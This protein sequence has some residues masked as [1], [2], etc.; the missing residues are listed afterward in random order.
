MQFKIYYESVKIMNRNILIIAIIVIIIAAV[1]VF[2]FTQPHSADGKIDTKINLLSENNLK[3]GDSVEFELKDKDG[4]ALA[5]ENINITLEKEDGNE[6]YSI[7]TDSN[8]KG[9]LVMDGV[10]AGTYKVY[11]VYGGSDKYNGFTAAA[12]IVIEEGTSDASSDASSSSNSSAST[13]SASTSSEGSSSASSSGNASNLHY[14]SEYNFYY[15]DNGVIRGG[16]SD[17]MSADYV[18]ESYKS[19]DMVDEEG[20][21]Q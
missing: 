5:N 19:G 10:S 15:D 11:V 1:G 4:N 14:D 18:R 20:N 9:A 8:G 2:L 17:G 12:Q 13:S 21:L 3:V 7:V 16:Q 6:T